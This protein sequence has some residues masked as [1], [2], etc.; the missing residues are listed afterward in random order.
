MPGSHD[1]DPEPEAGLICGEAGF[2]IARVASD[3][4]ADA[5]AQRVAAE[6]GA[7][8]RVRATNA[9]TSSAAA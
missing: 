8:A 7:E 5:G 1:I 4:V 2:L 9:S 3:P 6:I